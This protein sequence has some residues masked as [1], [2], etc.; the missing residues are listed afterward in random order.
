MCVCDRVY[1]QLSLGRLHILSPSVAMV[2]H[3]QQKGEGSGSHTAGRKRRRDE[4]P[5]SSHS[6][7][8]SVTVTTGPVGGGSRPC[9]SLVINVEH[10]E[11]VAWRNSGAGLHEGETG[12]MLC[13]SVRAALIGP[14]VSWGWDPKNGP[15][16]DRETETEKEDKV[17][18]S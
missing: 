6:D 18:N 8:S 10:K 12:L 9:V 13:F 2:T 15:M 1:L 16:S 3:L 11:G 14:V 17:R 4:E 7:S 5:D